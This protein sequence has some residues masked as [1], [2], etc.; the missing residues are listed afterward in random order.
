MSPLQRNLGIIGAVRDQEGHLD[1][2][3]NAVQMDVFGDPQE[4]VL[5]PG[6]PYPANM[7]P[8][9]RHWEAAFLL[10]PLLLHVTPIMVG[11]PR[12]AAS[13]ARLECDRAWAEIAAERT[14][15]EPDSFC[16]DIAS[17]LEPV[18]HAACPMLAVVARRHAV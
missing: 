7:G 11:A 6:A 14:T 15:R 4:F 13:K 5:I 9:V 3:E 10:Q 8:I 18:K 16:I 2:A 17:C 12:D 1:A